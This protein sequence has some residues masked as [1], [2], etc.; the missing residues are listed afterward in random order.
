M[1]ARPSAHKRSIVITGSMV[2]LFAIPQVPIYT[3]VRLDTIGLGTNLTL[4]TDSRSMLSVASSI[5][6]Y[7]QL[8]PLC[9]VL[10]FMRSLSQRTA[11][12]GI[13]VSMV[14]PGFAD[15]PLSAPFRSQLGNMPLVEMEDVA[16]AMIAASTSL[17]A[18]GVPVS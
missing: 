18:N 14:A 6:H 7:P 13:D 2:S 9:Q 3:A 1:Q 5:K 16:D 11:A 12:L 8:M 10:G 4:V 17:V 15:T